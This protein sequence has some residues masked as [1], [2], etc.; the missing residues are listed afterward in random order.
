MVDFSLPAS[1]KMYRRSYAWLA[2]S[3]GKG[4]GRGI[5]INLAEYERVR[6][7]SSLYKRAM[8]IPEGGGREGREAIG[9]SQQNLH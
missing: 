6:P 8:D 9:G 1:L 2:R 5:P 4:Q 7:P 3:L